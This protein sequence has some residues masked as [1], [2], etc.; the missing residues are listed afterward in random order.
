MDVE[1]KVLLAL[2]AIC[3]LAGLFAIRWVMTSLFDMAVG[4]TA[5]VGF[6]DAFIASLFISTAL[7]VL[8]AMVGGDGILGEFTSM[9]I[10]FFVMVAF[11]TVSIAVVL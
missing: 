7:V 5:G 1:D 11:F 8:F 4:A 10:A 9:V 2:I 3:V 6:G